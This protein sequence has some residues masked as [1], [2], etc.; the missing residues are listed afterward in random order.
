[1]MEDQLALSFS[2][3]GAGSCEL[4]QLMYGS[5]Y[6]TNLIATSWCGTGFS[7]PSRTYP[8]REELVSQRPNV[9]PVLGALL[10]VM[11]DAPQAAGPLLELPS[12]MVRG[13]VSSVDGEIH[14]TFRISVSAAS[15]TYSTTTDSAG[16]FS[17]A[18]PDGCL[19]ADSL[20]VRSD[21]PKRYLPAA[22]RWL[23]ICPGRSI[24]VLA[25]PR[26]LRVGN[27]S[28]PMSIVIG[29]MIPEGPPRSPTGPTLP[30]RFVLHC[31][32]P[33]RICYQ[34][35][36]LLIQTLRAAADDVNTL[37]G[38]DL[39]SLHNLPADTGGTI[40]I[41]IEEAS[42]G[43]DSAN[44]ILGT[45]LSHAVC[46]AWRGDACVVARQSID[47]IRLKWG[48]Y[49][50]G[51]LKH[52]AAHEFLHALGLKDHCAFPSLMCGD[53]FLES[54]RDA[55]SSSTITEFDVAVTR[56]AIRVAALTATLR[57]TIGMPDV[58]WTYD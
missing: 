56:F 39:I 32:G 6:P 53:S 13:I 23:R 16:R 37:I 18:L 52:L 47:V 9:L 58:L 45:T 55:G 21:H 4:R 31:N 44:A 49:P 54:V 41:E 43:D 28:L 3:A 27:D 10:L 36:P 20:V 30:L 11:F 50:A 26:F 34:H 33:T 25:L 2:L 29:S 5:R 8:R 46:N 22:V 1:M 51:T 17:L 40:P 12:Q 42:T 35:A 15:R 38:L 48:N 24:G 19:T 57:P 14:A 7:V